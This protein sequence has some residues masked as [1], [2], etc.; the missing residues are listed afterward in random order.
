M[1]YIVPMEIGKRFDISLSRNFKGYLKRW[2]R[3][4]V[5]GIANPGGANK[6]FYSR[7]CPVPYFM[8]SS[9]RVRRPGEEVNHLPLCFAEVKNEWIYASVFPVCFYDVESENFKKFC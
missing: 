2:R 3:I 4:G 8:G 1:Q 9:S 5:V 7:K 6:F